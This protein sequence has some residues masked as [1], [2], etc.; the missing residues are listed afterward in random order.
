MLG[1]CPCRG[2][3][4]RWH[5]WQNNIRRDHQEEITARSCYRWRKKRDV[6]LVPPQVFKMFSS[7]G[8]HQKTNA[9]QA[10]A[11]VYWWPRE[12]KEWQLWMYTRVLD[13]FGYCLHTVAVLL[14][15]EEWKRK[16]KNPNDYSNKFKCNMRNMK[17]NRPWRY[18]KGCDDEGMVLYKL[19]LQWC[20]DH[21]RCDPAELNK[22]NNHQAKMLTLLKD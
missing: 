3:W 12:G 21:K 4:Y 1:W 2:F 7:E 17:E 18:Q 10:K 14:N 15:F 20:K 16:K 8:Y 22:L 9:R 5:D 11:S 19:L 6:Q 13:C